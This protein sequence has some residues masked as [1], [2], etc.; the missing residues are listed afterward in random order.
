MIQ[1][2]AASRTEWIPFQDMLHF[3]CAWQPH[4]NRK[5]RRASRQNDETPRRRPILSQLPL[6]NPAP[7]EQTAPY[8]VHVM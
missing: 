3:E 2:Y 4:L 5:I 7:V 8:D 1:R 6:K